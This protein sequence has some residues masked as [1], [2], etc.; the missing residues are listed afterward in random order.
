M[1][2]FS[3]I[4]ITK[5]NSFGFQKTKQSIESQ[6]FKNFEWVVIDGDVEPDNGIYDAMNKGIDRACGNYL[7]FMNAG[8]CFANED[9]LSIIAEYCPADF[10]YGDALEESGII[11][12]ARHHSKMERGLITHHQA[13][14][15][16]HDVI[17]N[18]RYDETYKI[19]ADYK[20]TAHHII[21]SKTCTYIPQPLCI[22]AD[23]G[24]SKIHVKQGRKEQIAIRRE[25]KISAPF[26]PLRQLAAQ[27]I[28]NYAP[29][30]YLKLRV[31]FHQ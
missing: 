8:D 26:T 16:K 17:Q 18:R 2:Q 9:T 19:A 28:K 21:A 6:T 3:I 23:G 11:K 4:T 14:V 27:T 20:F 1:S 12:R 29:Q 15:Y 24:A 10:I 30:L 5:N 7:I 31:I 25:L 22:F 13:M